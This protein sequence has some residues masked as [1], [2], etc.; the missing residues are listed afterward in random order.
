[1]KGDWFENLVRNA[2]AVGFVVIREPAITKIEPKLAYYIEEYNNAA[3][4]LRLTARA[5]EKW[6]KFAKEEFDIDIAN[7]RSYN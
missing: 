5:M 3:S 6:R 4:L 7:D 1:M 2:D